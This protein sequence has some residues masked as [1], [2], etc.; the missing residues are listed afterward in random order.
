LL[1]R[2]G[3]DALLAVAEP[4]LRHRQ[5]A[6]FKPQARAI[7]VRHVHVLEHEAGHFG[8]AA[9]Q[10]QRR[11]SFAGHAVEHRFAGLDREIGDVADGLHGALGNAARSDGDCAPAATDRVDRVLQSLESPSALDHGELRARCLRQQGADRDR[12]NRQQ[13]DRTDQQPRGAMQRN[14]VVG[15]H[16]PG[17][18]KEGKRSV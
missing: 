6:A 1:S 2:C 13:G 10:H 14:L 17:L 15:V 5:V 16:A 7:V 8:R 11:L 4:R 3:K 18:A 12:R 9:A